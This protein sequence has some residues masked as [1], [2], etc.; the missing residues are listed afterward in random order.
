[1]TA[2]ELYYDFHLLLN[3]NNELKN[4]N[5]EAANFV[6]LYN[7][8][9]ERWLADYI[10]NNNNSDK[11]LNLDFFIIADFNLERI[12]STLTEDIY[13][14]PEDCFVIIEGDFR[15]EVSGQGCTG[16]VY[17]H[18]PK[19]QDVNSLLANKTT[20][21]SLHW[22]RGLAKLSQEGLIVFKNN[23]E[24]LKTTVSYYKKVPKIDLEG[25]T[26]FSGNLSSNIDPGYSDY[27]SQQILDRVITEVQRE[28]ENS[29]GFQLS[30]E[31]QRSF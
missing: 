14:L 6:R 31:R 7:R 8:E 17:N 1:M 11:F 4:I 30:Q 20:A 3:K 10:K 13:K 19:T 28:F 24:I 21:P 5:I 18:I 25:Y 27:I 22:E 16:I 12:S 15:S 29:V 26:D 23:F 2:Q 9:A